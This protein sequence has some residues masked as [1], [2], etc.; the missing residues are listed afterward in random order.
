[1]FRAKRFD[2]CVVGGL[3]DRLSSIG[4]RR[5]AAH[6]AKAG[7]ARNPSFDKKEACHE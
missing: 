5:G 7:V 2:V 3:R 4:C 6:V 1:M